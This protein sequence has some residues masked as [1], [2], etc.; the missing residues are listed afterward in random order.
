MDGIDAYRNGIENTDE[1]LGDKLVVGDLVATLLCSDSCISL[2]VLTVTAINQE[3]G[4]LSDLNLD[5]LTNEWHNIKLTGQVMSLTAM[6]ALAL[7]P[8]TISDMTISSSGSQDLMGSDLQT[9]STWSWL[10]A[11]GYVKTK[12]SIIG[13][14]EVS[15]KIIVVHVPGHLTMALNP[16]MICADQLQ[17][18]PLTESEHTQLNSKCLLW[19]F[20]NGGLGLVRD[21]LWERI[22]TSGI[23]PGSLTLVKPLTGFLYQL[24]G[25]PGLVCELGSNILKADQ[26][27]GV[28][29]VRNC[30]FCGQKIDGAP[31]WRSHIGE[32]IL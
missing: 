11:G 20:D 5:Q 27:Q 4:L 15:E 14:D 6:P 19:V 24:A 32:H 29:L 31:K 12:S 16:Q 22:S 1:A 2:A 9:M 3:T 30:H 26:F 10:W 25:D 23:A 21:T 8:D 28:D 13:T 17:D 7:V 18:L